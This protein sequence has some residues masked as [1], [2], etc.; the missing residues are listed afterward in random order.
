LRLSAQT[1]EDAAMPPKRPPIRTGPATRHASGPSCRGGASSLLRLSRAENGRLPSL[2]NL[3]RWVHR[4]AAM[5]GA[6][7]RAQLAYSTSEFGV[8]STG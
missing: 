4:A 3:S 8:G 5:F 7:P 2:T 1:A 6:S